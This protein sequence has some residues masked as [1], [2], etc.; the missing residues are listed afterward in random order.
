MEID[1][2]I[3][4]IEELED[5]LAHAFDESREK[6]NYTIEKK[7]VQFNKDVKR[8]QRQF[9]AGVFRYLFASGFMAIV[10]SPVVYA[11]IFP[12]IILDIFVTIYQFVCFP[13][14]N[15]EKAKRADFIAVDR[16]H[17]A[18]LNVIEKLNCL[19]CS[20][21]NGL[22]AYARE[23]A[24]RSEAHWCP[25]KHARR[26]KGQHRRYWA[27]AEYGDAEGHSNKEAENEKKNSDRFGIN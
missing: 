26:T 12:L 11:L 27:F 21:A 13:I 18:Y 7:R 3:E 1:R 19:Y 17:L 5:Q 15:I 10:F 25:I 8:H 14:Y 6:F 9:K 22:L 20:Y 4:K 16:H 24:G 2:I 23:I